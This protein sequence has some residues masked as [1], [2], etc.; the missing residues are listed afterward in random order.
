MDPSKIPS[1][2]PWILVLFFSFAR[3]D[4]PFI[5]G[6]TNGDGRVH[7]VD[8]ANLVLLESWCARFR[9][10]IVFDSPVECDLKRT[11]LMNIFPP[12]TFPACAQLE[13]MACEDSF[14]VNDD[15]VLYAEL[16]HL[17]ELIRNRF[18]P[19]ALSSGCFEPCEVPGPDPM[20]DGLGCPSVTVFEPIV[21]E[22]ITVGTRDCVLPGGPKWR[23]GSTGPARFPSTQSRRRC[24]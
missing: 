6:D 20:E 10:D 19:P 13:G 4:E 23:R 15:G 22:T 3:A 21:D 8:W 12:Y 17:G 2:S 1:I 5:R 11:R 14:D 24:M 7:V 18:L 9:D 16:G